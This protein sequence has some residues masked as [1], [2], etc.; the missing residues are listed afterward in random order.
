M[1]LQQSIQYGK[2]ISALQWRVFR[3]DGAQMFYKKIPFM[4]GLL[5]IQRPDR[6][7][8]LPALRDIITKHSVRTVAI[9]PH[10]KQNTSIYKS[11]CKRLAKY[12]TVVRSGYMP[13][14]TILIDIK[15]DEN[16]I[17]RRFSEA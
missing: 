11:W 17:F 9:E 16:E 10:Q 8:S 6:L 13:T 2:Y 5:K 3:V 14:K 1:E 12:C 4:G 15:P 7:P